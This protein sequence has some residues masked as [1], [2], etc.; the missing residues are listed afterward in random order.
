MLSVCRNLFAVES[1]GG[2]ERLYDGGCVSD[3]ERIARGTSQHADDRQPDVGRTLR[4]IATETDTQHVR[5]RL[6]Q[7]PR[8]LLQP[9]RV[10]HTYYIA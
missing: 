5:Q 6:E 4:W 7:R 9:T 3:E 1:S 10:L 8:I 2:I